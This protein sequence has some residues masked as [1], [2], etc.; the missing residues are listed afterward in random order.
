MDGLS[1]EEYRNFWKNK[2]K[3]NREKSNSDSTGHVIDLNSGKT[4]NAKVEM[5]RGNYTS[6]FSIQNEDIKWC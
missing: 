3:E 5:K 4:S 6:H 1:L 2:L